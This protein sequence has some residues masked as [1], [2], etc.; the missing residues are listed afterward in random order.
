MVWVAEGYPTV[1]RRMT[2]IAFPRIA[3]ASLL[4]A[5]ICCLAIRRQIY[6]KSEQRTIFIWL[7]LSGLWG[8]PILLGLMMSAATLNG[9]LDDS[10]PGQHASELIGKKSLA[11]RGWYSRSLVVRDWRRADQTAVLG[12]LS[13]TRAYDLWEPGR[14]LHVTTRKGFFDA[15]W[16]V[17]IE[18]GKLDNQ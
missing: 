9:W 12:G 4:V 15:E 10:L 18:A 3:S 11:G 1:N 7:P 5:L 2:G 16:I 8:A 14:K 13:A 6:T 17:D